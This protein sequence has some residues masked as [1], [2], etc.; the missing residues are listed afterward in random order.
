MIHSFKKFQRYVRMVATAC[1]FFACKVEE[2]PRRLREFIEAIHKL[3]HSKSAA[4][5]E[6]FTHNSEEY[7]K[8]GE[9]IVAFE[10]CLLQTLGF[11][12]LVNHAHTVIIKTCQMIKAPRDLAEAAYLTATNSLILTN[13]CVK[14]SC[15]KVACF[16]IYLACKWTQLII[17]TSSEGMQWYQYVKHDIVEQELEDISKEYLS[18]FDKCSP[19]IQR[20]LGMTKSSDDQMQQQQKQA[21]QVKKEPKPSHHPQQQQQQ[22]Q[23]PHP[24]HPSSQSIQKHPHKVHNQHPHHNGHL[25]SH[26][27]TNPLKSHPQQA[28]PHSHH[29]QQQHYPQGHPMHKQAHHGQATHAQQHFKQ[30]NKPPNLSTNHHHSSQSK[31][32]GHPPNSIQQTGVNQNDSSLDMTKGSTNGQSLKAKVQQSQ[33]QQQQQQQQAQI[34]T[35]PLNTSITAGSTSIKRINED[36]NNVSSAP[37]IRKYVIDQ[38]STT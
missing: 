3:F 18:I 21:Q 4:S 10:S 29:H 9:E 2:Q 25:S 19:K 11:N 37:K 15:E 5:N 14:F 38:N 36:L 34:K 6:P 20:K 26:H 28:H 31:T 13:F 32:N 12:V 33:Q 8:Y 27:S 23:Q 7:R 16:C 17:P 24:H 30:H 35:S 1:L 22:Q